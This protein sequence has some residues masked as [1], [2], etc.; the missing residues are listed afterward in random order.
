MR[1]HPRAS[2][3]F[4]GMTLADPRTV[5]ARTLNGHDLPALADR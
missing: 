2:V 5:C 3:E 4:V 1:V